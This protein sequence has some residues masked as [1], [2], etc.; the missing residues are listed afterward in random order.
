MINFVICDDNVNILDK[1][2]KTLENIFAI[3]GF[4]AEVALTTNNTDKLLN[5][6]ES[7]KTDVLILDINLKSN[8]SGLE[9][10]QIVR[11]KNKDIYIIFTTAHLE[12]AMVAYKVKTF[13]YIAKPI[14]YDRLEDTIKRLFDDING[15]PKKYIK[16]DSKNT[17][18]DASEILYIKRDGMKIVFKTET[19]DYY[20]YSSFNKIQFNLPNNFVRC[21]KSYI[22]NINKIKDVE[23]VT[24]TV[25]FNDGNYCEIGPKYKKSLMEVLNVYGIS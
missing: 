20:T 19:Q 15:L 14:T 24:N 9:I 23:P 16:I 21:H 7:T 2:S 18:V 1:L 22:A 8:K 4:D 25:T 10:A 3:N 12:Y 11:E 17:L 6:V 13:D 5:F